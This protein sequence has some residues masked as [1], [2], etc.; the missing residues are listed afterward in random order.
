MYFDLCDF[1]QT[2]G[3][4]MNSH[5]GGL[6]SGQITDVPSTD[7]FCTMAGAERKVEEQMQAKMALNQ[8]KKLR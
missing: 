4:E 1:F 7:G 8:R 3:A 5:V 2:Q 6:P